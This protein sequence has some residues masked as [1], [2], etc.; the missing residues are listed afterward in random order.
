MGKDEII[1]ILRNEKEVFRIKY[2]ADL[3][4]IF[5]SVARGEENENSDIDILAEFQPKATLLDL[6]GIKI[7]LEERLGK[8]VDILST[9]SINPEF[10][11]YIYEDLILLWETWNSILKI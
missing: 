9:R 3:K 11:K 5:G 8:K 10:V 6:S 7:S 1:K 4:G 2:K